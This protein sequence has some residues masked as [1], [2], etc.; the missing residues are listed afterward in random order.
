MPPSCPGNI[1]GQNEVARN[2]S[3]YLKRMIDGAPSKTF[4]CGHTDLAALSGPISCA[5]FAF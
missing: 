1:Q 4:Q 2:R 5:I 3:I